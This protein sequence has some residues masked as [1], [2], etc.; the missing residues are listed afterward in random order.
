MM[1]EFIPIYVERSGETK[2]M[3]ANYFKI[4]IYSD[5][6]KGFCEFWQT[7]ILKNVTKHG[8]DSKGIMAKWS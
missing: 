7:K 8:C 1:I 3:H 6:Q 4:D 5:P 2:E